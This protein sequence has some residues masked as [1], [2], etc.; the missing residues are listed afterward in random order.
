MAEGLYLPDGLDFQG[1]GSGAFYPEQA[2]WGEAEGWGSA[3]VCWR[4]WA[5]SRA[6]LKSPDH[7]EKQVQTVPRDDGPSSLRHQGCRAPPPPAATGVWAGHLPGS[8]KYSPQFA[9]P[10][11][12]P[13][14]NTQ[15]MSIPQRDKELLVWGTL[16]SYI[17][18]VKEAT[19]SVNPLL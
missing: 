7:T 8:G 6:G 17:G 12:Y 9:F 4:E 11:I 10:G 13:L 15:E 16:L 3:T 1:S 18:S 19:G 2:E 14:G 5:A